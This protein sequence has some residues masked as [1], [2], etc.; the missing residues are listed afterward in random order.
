MD[1][2]DKAPFFAIS[3]SWYDDAYAKSKSQ[4]PRILYHY[5]DAAGLEGMLR[6]GNL[7]ITDY[8]FLNDRSEVIHSKALARDV[9]LE[10]LGGAT[11]RHLRKLYEDVLRFQDAEAAYVPFVFSLSE[12]RDD[13]SQWRGYARDGQGFTIGLCTHSVYKESEPE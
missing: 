13:L 10:R 9:I 3:R 11:E 8:R 6:N 5:T 2:T 7:W 1:E 4:L 12:K